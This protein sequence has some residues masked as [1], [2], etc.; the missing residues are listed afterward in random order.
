MFVAREITVTMEGQITDYNKR[1]YN[2]RLAIALIKEY[3][4]GTCGQLLKILE[5]RSEAR[6]E[7]RSIEA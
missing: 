2:E 4:E 7:K 3:G 6:Y 1:L 5:A